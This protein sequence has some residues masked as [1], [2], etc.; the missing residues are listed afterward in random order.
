MNDT[1]AVIQP[2][3]KLAQFLIDN[4]ETTLEGESIVLRISTLDNP[5]WEVSSIL[6]NEAAKNDV[7]R[8][9]V[10]AIDEESED[11]WT[12]F[13]Q[14]YAESAKVLMKTDVVVTAYGGPLYLPVIAEKVY[15][16]VMR[17]ILN[18]NPIILNDGLIDR[19]STWR[20]VQCDGEWEHLD[21]IRIALASTGQWKFQATNVSTHLM[22]KDLEW[23]KRPRFPILGTKKVWMRDPVMIDQCWYHDSTEIGGLAS[24]LETFLNNS[25]LDP[26]GLPTGRC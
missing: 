3:E 6:P 16:R 7:E 22:R 2:L 4:I 17:G 5:G 19:I 8:K 12:C 15:S 23:E 10:G 26:A 13:E 18:E 24:M 1:N 9:S 11:W 25:E 14:K 21:G 20:Q